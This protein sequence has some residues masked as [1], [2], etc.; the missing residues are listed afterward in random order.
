MLYIFCS[1]QKI[2]I[3]IEMLAEYRS[4]MRTLWLPEAKTIRNSSSREV[5]G[6]VTK[7]GFSYSSGQS[8]AVGYIVLCGIPHLNVKHRNVV[9]IRNTTSRQYR[10]ATIE[11]A[12]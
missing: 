8:C 4:K 5:I 12:L 1:L 2:P 6:F 7:G 10:Q 9:L 11:I 3:D